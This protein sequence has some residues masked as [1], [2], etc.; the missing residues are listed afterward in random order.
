MSRLPVTEADLQSAVIVAAQYRG[1]LVAHSRPALSVSGWRTPV[2]GNAGF[3]DL[4]LARAGVVFVWELKGPRG[5]PAPEQLVWLD[6]LAGGVTDARVVGPD[7]LDDALRALELGHWP[8]P[9]LPSDP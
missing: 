2:Q 1:W 7:D 9:A 6:Q 3:P 8:T 4:V 5:K